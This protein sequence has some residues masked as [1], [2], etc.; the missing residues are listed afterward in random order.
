M[1]SSAS[2]MGMRNF[3]SLICDSSF[4]L[5]FFDYNQICKLGRVVFE[6]LVCVSLRDEII[7]QSMVLIEPKEFFMFKLHDDHL[8]LFF[9]LVI[10]SRI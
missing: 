9:L 1:V 3:D 6:F 8:W 4:V 10:F 5:E 7:V 2:Y